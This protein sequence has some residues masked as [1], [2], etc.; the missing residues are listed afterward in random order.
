MPDDIQA[1]LD[2]VKTSLEDDK[3]LDITVIPLLG[4]TA[5]ADF[6][7]VATGTSQ[8]HVAA[9][10]EKLSER[11]VETGRDKPAMEGLEECSWVLID[12]VDILVHVFRAETR[13]FYDI[14]R[15]WSVTP[16]ER[17]QVAGEG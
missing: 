1:L 17:L 11:I 5:I 6:M 3:G 10:A 7:V 16:P 8:R 9:L 4:K 14:E 12:A 2:L 13:A 15:L